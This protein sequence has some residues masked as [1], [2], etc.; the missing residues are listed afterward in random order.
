[1]VKLAD[2]ITVI[3]AGE[4]IT[5]RPSLR[6]AIRL[7]RRPGS[8]AKLARDVMDGSLTAACDIIRD[9]AD[10]RFLE[11]R[12][13]DAG[14]ERLQS[15]LL[16]YVMALA[17]IDP[18]DAPANDNAKNAT[19]A[20]SRKSV[21]F[22]EHLAGLYRIGTGW[23]G[24]TPD[25]TLDATPAEISEAY[26]GRLDMLKAIFGASDT[27]D[28]PSNASLDDKFKSAFGSIGTVKVKRKKK[29]A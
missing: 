19:V 17:G 20:Y 13:F 21:P 11:T 9:H 28:A 22:S 15:P 18:E 8:F 26:Q 3:L 12:I 2:D 16:A 5:L 24:W 14:I 23:L 29:A 25:T 1:M 4:A 6:F 7:E 10:S 27:E